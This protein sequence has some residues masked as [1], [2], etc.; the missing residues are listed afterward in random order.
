M[1]PH[2]HPPAVT[3]SLSNRGI[4]H[5]KQS[6]AKPRVMTPQSSVNFPKTHLKTAQNSE[7][8][9]KKR[10][11]RAVFAPTTGGIA[12]VLATSPSSSRSMSASTMCR[13]NLSKW[14]YFTSNDR[15]LVYF[16]LTAPSPE[17][18]RRGRLI[19]QLHRCRHTVC[20]LQARSGGADLL[21]DRGE[22]TRSIHLHPVLPD[23][24][25]AVL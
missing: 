7:K 11:M 5:S 21:N 14:P 1:H 23:V 2:S 18:G 9:Y 3:R 6:S 22:L 15:L 16:V 20:K 8:H 25:V 24:P 19:V 17:A 4:Y 13:N 12:C 10:V